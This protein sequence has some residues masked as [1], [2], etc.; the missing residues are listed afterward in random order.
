MSMWRIFCMAFAPWFALTGA[1]FAQS[2]QIKGIEFSDSAYLSDADLQAIELQYVDRPLVFADLEK[3][4]GDV[5]TLYSRAGVLTAQALLPPQD[6]EDGILKVSLVEADIQS[7]AIDGLDR[8]NPAFLRRTISL[9]ENERPDFDQLERDLR[10]YEVMHDIRPRLSFAP[11]TEVGTTIA[12]ISGE[13]TDPFTSTFSLDNFG[14]EETGE[15]RA[16]YFGRWTSV[17]GVRDTLSFKLQR[18]ESSQS[19]SAGYSRPVGPYSGRVEATLSYS[20]AEV[21]NGPFQALEILSE[22]SGAT[23]SYRQPFRVGPF[24][25]WTWEAGLA[26]ETSE[27]TL[28]GLTFSDIEIQEFYGA[29]SYTERAENYV[30]SATGGFRV[31]EA[32]TAQISET[33][34]SYAL[35]YGSLA[36]TRPLG[37]K[38]LF[39]TNVIG[40]YAEGENLPVARLFTGGGPDILRGYPNNVRSGDSGFVARM[41]ISGREAISLGESDF[42]ARPFGF[43]DVGLIVPF[44]PDGG[45]E[46]D[47]D[48]LASAGAGTRISYRDNASM[49]LMAGLPL[50][51]TLGFEDGE[52]TVYFGLDYTF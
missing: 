51:E 47:Q 34:G 20:D 14:R 48:F 15:L 38:L 11:G 42:K 31:G 9:R 52:A 12:T 25:H 19:F 44:R 24:S 8:T 40:Q 17:T 16:A 4:L 1:A 49:L 18:S 36:Y 3:M 50:R 45:I 32:D 28:L 30:I 22:S 43:L 13:E 21:I 7:V 2:F 41:Q 37:K 27:S 39:E 6:V 5:Q 26:Y 10:I 29:V 33:E 46:S 35:L 23:L